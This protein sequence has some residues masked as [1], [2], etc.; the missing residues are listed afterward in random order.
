M[1]G[2][3]LLALV[4][5]A[6]EDP[7]DYVRVLESEDA[8]RWEEAVDGLLGEEDELPAL[9]VSSVVRRLDHLPARLRARVAGALGQLPW[10]PKSLG[11]L[12]A[13]SRSG[14]GNVERS[15]TEALWS[16]RS[17]GAMDVFAGMLHEETGN[18]IEALRALVATYRFWSERREDP[19][20]D[21]IDL[22][23]APERGS[24]EEIFDRRY[25]PSVRMLLRSDDRDE[26]E[27]AF[28][29]TSA[30][31]TPGLRNEWALL[32]GDPDPETRMEAMWEL[33][34]RGDPRP[35]PALFRHALEAD[36]RR[37]TRSVGSACAAR[38]FL[39]YFR[40]YEE[41]GD[42]IERAWYREMIEGA[43]DPDLL[44]HGEIVTGLAPYAHHTSDFLRE[45]A[46]RVLAWET[47][48]QGEE[49]PSIP[50]HLVLVATVSGVVGALLFVLAFRIWGLAVRVRN[51]PVTKAASLALGP[52]ALQGEAQPAGR[53]LPHPVT[54][55]PT[56][57]FAGA[58]AGARFY[59]E[60]DT[61][62]VLVDPQG[63]VLFSQDDILVPGER[64]HVVGYATR[65]AGGEIVVTAST[66][67]PPLY[68]RATDGIIRALFG[69]GRSTAVTRMLFTDPSRCFWIWDD[70]DR[71]PMSESRDLLWLGASVLLGGAWMVVFAVAVIGIVDQEFAQRI[72]ETLAS[73]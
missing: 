55:E 13:L 65:E 9:A 41:A 15:A 26:R 56:V 49:S 4:V 66:V 17:P 73:P 62:R 60:D 45:T 23:M 68:R 36:E 52:V 21:R 25:L 18:R 47:E 58:P 31:D 69:L 44:E 61:G 14:D 22:V 5:V 72:A 38:H 19:A 70:L 40:W 1:T 28:A 39:H 29:I 50:S 57:F 35:C 53:V 37:T 51:Q 30:I 32:L 16:L 11:T 2:A 12:V 59:L 8:A 46:V 24:P 34:G 48:S 7:S 64:I 42:D 27:K 20:A 43:T 3:V 10:H 33:A 54:G 63:V 71:R 67:T 6:A